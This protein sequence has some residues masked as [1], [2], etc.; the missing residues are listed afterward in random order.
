[1]RK[2]LFIIIAALC[3]VM[4]TFAQEVIP[5]YDYNSRQYGIYNNRSQQWV[6]RP[7]FKSVEYMGPWDGDY[8]FCVETENSKVGIIRS[9]DYSH[10]YVNPDYDEIKYCQFSYSN[11]T[12]LLAVRK[13]SDWGLYDISLEQ[14]FPIKYQLIV[15]YGTWVLIRDWNGKD[16]SL[17]HQNIR[18]MMQ[19]KAESKTREEA[20]KR[21]Q[22]EEMQ[23]IESE[24]KAREKKEAELASFTTYA[25]NYVQPKIEAWQ[26]KG[27]YEKTEA[28]RKR[29]TGGNRQNKIDSLTTEAE[30]LFI[31]EHAA[32]N[33][34]QNLHISGNYDADNEVYKLECTKFGTMLV[35]VP[36]ADAPSFKNNFANI[37]MRN[38]KYFIENDKIALRSVDFYNPQT[39]RTYSYNNA[40]ALHYTTYSLDADALNLKAFTISSNDNRVV[41]AAD[42]PIVHILD[43]STDSQYSNADII[44]RCNI[45]TRDGST[46][47]LY[48]E[49]NGAERIVVQPKESTQAKG[50]K[51]MAG[52]EYALQLPTD[53]EHPCNLAF[54]AEGA[55]NVPSE[56]KKLRLQYVGAKPKPTL[57]VFSVGVGEY[58]SSDLENLKYAAKDAQQFEQTIKNMAGNTYSKVESQLITNKSATKQNIETSLSKLTNE[59]Q[60]GDVVMLFFSGHGVKDGDDAY[61]MPTD[62]VAADPA[63]NS[64]GFS[65]IKNRIRRVIDKQCTVIL[66]M[67]ACH[68]GAMFKY[69]G[70]KDWSIKEPGMVGFY[71]STSSEESAEVDKLENGAFT[72]ALLDGLS[73]KAA[74]PNGQITTLSLQNYITNEVN[75]SNSKQTPLVENPLGEILLLEV[76]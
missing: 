30:H 6:V 47:T 17:S 76:K 22:A 48:V 13:G 11:F 4:S 49:I 65:Y 37:Q 62:G 3:C 26:H 42:K 69:K 58:A 52:K 50:A 20:I 44:I 45:E 1:M 59:V 51:P 29:V 43:P 63:P 36:I 41:T 15:P 64:V 39:Q 10:F 34:L 33:P 56:V 16:T 72:H 71:S 31:N 57:H 25:Q 5:K 19:Q 40:A 27:E 54:Y 66:F 46:P 73:G 14:L 75:K 18:N 23:R 61:F 32:L 70:N 2:Q 28:Y 8:Y 60:Q 24:R 35:N 55:N 7:M 12:P 9:K 21:Q 74:N 53:R 68:S 67:D 38:A